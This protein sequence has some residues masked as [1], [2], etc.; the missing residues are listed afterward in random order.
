[1][2]LT[3]H[4]VCVSLVPLAPLFAASAIGTA[5]AQ[6][7]G[8]PDLIL[9]HGTI[10]TVDPRDTVTQAIAI[11]DGRVLR[12]GTDA[13][14]LALAGSHTTVVDLHGRTATPGLIDTHVHVADG[15]VGEVT[16]IELG[17]ATGVAEIVQRV[18]AKAAQ[19]KPGEWVR[20]QGWDEGKLTEHRYVVAADLDA[21][22]PDNPVWLDQTTGHYGVANSYALRLGKVSA[23]T[24]DPPA[25]TIDRDRTGAPTGVLK[26]SAQ[27]LVTHLIPAPTSEQWREGIRRMIKTLHS[28]GMTAFKDPD[29][30]QP[31]WDAY[32]ALL[33]SGELTVHVCVLWHAGA[34]V[35]SAQQALKTIQALP[36]PPQSL[37]DG[38]LLSCGAKIYMDGSGA[39][40]TA[41]MYKEWSKNW[42]EVDHGNTGYPAEDPAVYRQM[43]RLLH[44]AGVNVGTHAVGERAID[45]VVDT[46][47]E[48]LRETP[49]RG[50]RHSIIHGNL[51]TEHAIEV[52]AA[53]QRRYDAGY[54]EMQPPF[55]WWIGDNY[56]GNLGP[57]RAQRLEPLRTLL[58]RGVQWTGGSDFNVTPVAARYGLWA[59]VERETLK[60]TYELHPFG[61]AEAVDVH[62]AL[63][64][65]TATA[66]RQL[67]LEDKI[68]SLEPGKEADIAVWDRNPYAVPPVELKQMKCEMTLFHGKVVYES[69]PSQPGT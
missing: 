50:L 13:T 21:A 20:G 68:G 34:S 8:A 52:M 31:M 35:A 2:N 60:G 69:Q 19:L 42:T 66:A 67:F 62:A 9:A 33:D 49:T 11:R 32:R 15:G 47:A 63:R 29:D 61:T 53:L 45:W 26:E 37:G 58:S 28:E 39:A 5:A 36:R 14:V 41:W 56:A 23:D 38:R 6:S 43:V 65:Y 1:M 59:A 12:V 10:L 48:V 54:P 18:R 7:S 24:A 17:D 40:R 3:T 51:P 46:Y 55:I 57:D 64:A 4:W 30:T 27:E 22:A 44:R 25:G 16:G